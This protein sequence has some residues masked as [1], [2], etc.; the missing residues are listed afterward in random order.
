MAQLKGHI[1]TFEDKWHCH[2]S[3]GV[4]QRYVEDNH[5]AVCQHISYVDNGN[6]RWVKQ[7]ITGVERKPK[8][9][10]VPH[11]CSVQKESLIIPGLGSSPD[12]WSDCTDDIIFE[13]NSVVTGSKPGH[14]SPKYAKNG[15]V[16]AGA[17]GKY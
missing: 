12:E 6:I 10:Q 9:I 4:Y 13:D 17:S 5:Q 15:P 7:I 8:Y 1:R 2:E 3:I 11:E 16:R 14:V